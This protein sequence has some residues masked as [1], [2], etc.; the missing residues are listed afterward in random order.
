LGNVLLRA[1]DGKLHLT[2]S[3]LE[4]ELC[5]EANLESLSAAGDITVPARKLFDIC[6]A[7]PDNSTIEIKLEHHKIYLQAGNSR[8]NLTTLPAVEY[9]N[10]QDNTQGIEFNIQISQLKILI[11]RTQFAM[12]H[13]DVRYYLNGSLWEIEKNVL[14]MV[15]T[16]GHRL[17]LGRVAV[18]SSEEIGLA[19]VIVPRKAIVELLRMLDD[20]D[21]QLGVV[22]GTNTIQFRNKRYLLTSKLIDG[23][24]PEYQNVIPKGGTNE[25][26]IERDLLKPVLSRVAILSNE[27]CRGVR[28]NLEEN[29]LK[30]TANNP[31]H[32]EAEEHIPVEYSGDAMEVAFN[33]NYLLD[34]L[35]NGVAAQPLLITLAGGEQGII[36]EY[37]Q[38]PEQVV[39]VIMPMR[40]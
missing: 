2:G 34:I 33:V 16:D 22:I 35:N 13:Q 36:A 37:K 23:R 28:L 1:K 15:A 3:D 7:L 29:L 12:A 11:E 20:E 10:V 18:E 14:T 6:R 30:V 17:A 40:L 19:K 39:N 9:P 27:K 4:V 5:A 21:E 8:F 26:L 38:D 25:L 24:Y 32:E 31:E